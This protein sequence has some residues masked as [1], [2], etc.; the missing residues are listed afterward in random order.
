[1][2]GDERAGVGLGMAE[3]RRVVDDDDVA[4]RRRGGQVCGRQDQL[5]ASGLRR[6][7]GL[8]PQMAGSVRKRA[9]WAHHRIAVGAQRRQPQRELTRET[10]DPADLGP[11][12]SA[13]VNRDRS[14]RGPD[15]QDH[16]DAT[17]VGLD[18]PAEH[19]AGTDQPDADG[20][21]DIRVEAG[22]WERA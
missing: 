2:V 21:R 22:V 17:L 18:A 15:A 12:R 11:D 4:P 14:R 9:R 8:F 13:S 16:R 5:G 6:E 1:M 3:R 7:H 10:L 19:E 20:D